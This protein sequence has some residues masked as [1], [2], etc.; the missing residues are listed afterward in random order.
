MKN[1]QNS[2][3]VP[4]SISESARPMVKTQP[5]GQT[6]ETRSDARLPRTV[7]R[8]DKRLTQMTE[9]QPIETAPLAE[10]VL[11]WGPTSIVRSAALCRDETGRTWWTEGRGQI[12]IK[13]THWAPLPEPPDSPDPK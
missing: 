13:L 1:S 8:G 5:S 2:C 6:K 9:W 12:T 4:L 10:W 7:L 11:V 3:E